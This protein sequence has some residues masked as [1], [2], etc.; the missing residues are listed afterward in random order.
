MAEKLDKDPAT[1]DLAQHLAQEAAEEEERAE[2]EAVEGEAQEAELES[3]IRELASLRGTTHEKIAPYAK[4][5]TYAFGLARTIESYRESLV[6]EH[7]RQEAR[8]GREAEEAHRSNTPGHYTGCGECRACK[9]TAILA[10]GR[11]PYIKDEDRNYRPH[12]GKR[13]AHPRESEVIL[14]AEEAELHGVD[15]SV[16]ESRECSEKVHRSDIECEFTPEP[17]AA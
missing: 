10:D 13:R 15:T 6:K 4:E 17:V 11:F 1:F 7:E 16:F 14:T 2:R 3:I 5:M 12:L 9:Y 8:V